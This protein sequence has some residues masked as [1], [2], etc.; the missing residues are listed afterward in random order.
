MP[1]SDQHV[2]EAQLGEVECVAESPCERKRQNGVAVSRA[3][4]DDNL[5][6][7]GAPLNHLLFVSRSVASL[8]LTLAI[9]GAVAQSL[10]SASV[11]SA[12]LDATRIDL[13]DGKTSR[14]PAARAVP[15]DLVEYRATYS[16]NGKASIADVL[17]VIPVPVGTTFVA[18]SASPSSGVQASADGGQTFAPIPLKRIVKGADE[19]LHEELVPLAEYRVL[20]WRIAALAAEKD[21]FVSLRVQ[22]DPPVAAAVAATAKP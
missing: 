5:Q 6:S 12:R 16:N 18:G 22:F 13:A 2:G 4:I 10:S 1:H 8:A 17:A 19:K 21:T 3:S 11:L 7:P 14:V 9:G 20:R 15:G